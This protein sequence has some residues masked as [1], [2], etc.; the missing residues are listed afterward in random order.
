MAGDSPQPS[1]NS[2]SPTVWATI[3]VALFSVGGTLVV[4]SQN[5][6]AQ[7]ELEREQFESNLILKAISTG[8]KKQSY[9]NIRFLVE[10]HLIRKESDKVSPLLQDT[11]FHFHLSEDKPVIQSTSPTQAAFTTPIADYEPTFS[12]V[13][14]DEATGKPLKGVRIAV[15]TRRSRMRDIETQITGEDG[16]FK[17]HYPL[18]SYY[19]DYTLTGYVGLRTL[20]SAGGRFSGPIKLK[21][22]RVGS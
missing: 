6:T 13:I 12:G 22:K 17:L 11:S 4:A 14:V 3:I 18:R 15:N 7:R 1:S 5:A 19:L 2:I 16:K 10:A 9:E 8:D 21:M 20:Y